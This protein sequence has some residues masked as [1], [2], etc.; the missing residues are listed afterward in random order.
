MTDADVDGSHIRTLLLTFLF[1]ELPQLISNGNVYIAQPPLYKVKKGKNERYVIDDDQLNKIIV[2]NAIEGK[3][4]KPLKKK[5]DLKGKEFYAVINKYMALTALKE[6]LSRQT[7]ELTATA[8]LKTKPIT[9]SEASNKN[10]FHSWVKGAQRKAKKLAKESGTEI[11]FS[12]VED[13]EGFLYLESKEQNNGRSLTGRIPRTFFRSKE[14]QSIKAY[15]DLEKNFRGGVVI[16]EGDSRVEYGSLSDGLGDLIKNSKKG[17]SIQRYKGLGEMNPGQL[18]D[19][20]LDPETRSLVQ[21]RI[22]DEIEA[23]LTFATLMG[24]EVYPRRQFI[25]ENALNVS[26]LDV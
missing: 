20:T 16:N 12:V 10:K 4:L 14:Y 21:V 13:D 24:E 8:I 15:Q 23:D 3:A 17:Q 22:E 19:T 18:W 26:N 9:K 5:K 6:R 7:N 11:A 25:E 1:R 2:S